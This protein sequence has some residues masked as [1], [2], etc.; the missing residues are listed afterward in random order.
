MIPAIDLAAIAPA[1]GALAD[2]A[3]P[4]GGAASSAASADATARGLRFLAGAYTIVWVILAVYMMSLSIRLRRL[5]RQVRRLKE[6]L[7]G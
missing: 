4:V 7:G 6:R 3:V 2:Q 5:A 1:L